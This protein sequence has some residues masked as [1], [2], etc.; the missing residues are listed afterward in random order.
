[1]KKLYCKIEYDKYILLK[2]LYYKIEYVLDS[3]WNIFL[4]YGVRVPTGWTAMARVSKFSEGQNQTERIRSPLYQ[5]LN[6][7]E[8][9]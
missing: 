6:L 3:T 8:L 1:L 2:K 9:G 5:L 7:D 4:D